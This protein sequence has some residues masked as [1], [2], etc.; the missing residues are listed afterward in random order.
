[1]NQLNINNNITMSSQ[2]I[3][4]LVKSRHDSVKRTIERLME[5]AI[6]QLTPLVDVKNSQGQTVASY[7]LAKRDSLVVVAQLSPEFTGALVDRWQELENNKGLQLPQTYLQALEQLVNTEKE[8]ARLE[9]INNALLHTLKTYTASELAKELGI[10][11]ASKLNIMLK[12]KGIQYKLN[13]TW[14]LYA[15]YA[16]LGLQEVKQGISD[17]GH[18]YYNSQFTNKGREF[19]LSLL[20]KV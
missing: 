7:L 10:R 20:G 8:R 11:S 1:M 5:K 4:E 16:E 19:V 2:E 18:I 9:S 17:N 13:G 15:K 3:A 12:D 6:I 14:V